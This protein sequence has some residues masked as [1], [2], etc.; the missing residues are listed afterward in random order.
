MACGER[1]DRDIINASVSS[2]VA[3]V[4]NSHLQNPPRRH[5]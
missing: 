1:E 3:P 2:V 4:Q 5:Q